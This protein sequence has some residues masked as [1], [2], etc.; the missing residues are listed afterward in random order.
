MSRRAAALLLG[1]ALL[2][3]IL[4][5]VW[6]WASGEKGTAGRVSGED[7]EEETPGR[8]ATFQVV[9]YFPAGDGRLHPEDRELVAPEDRK[10]RIRMVVEALLQGPEAPG[11]ASPFGGGVELGGVYL[12]EDGIAYIDLWSPEEGAPPPSG[13][14]QEMLRVYSLVNSVVANVSEVRRVVLLWNGVQPTSFGG[15][16][17]TAHPL[18]LNR[19]LLARR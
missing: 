2:V 4:G 6:W 8:E 11:L 15:H 5:T 9:L 10:G 12:D 19:D 13:S 7:K 3:V 1:S 17:D 16:L 14:R 18:A